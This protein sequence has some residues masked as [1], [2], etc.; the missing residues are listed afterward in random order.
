MIENLV[1]LNPILWIISFIVWIIFLLLFYKTKNS[2]INFVFIK[3]LQKIYKNSNYIFFIN[4]F[5]IFILI[6]IFSIIIA[7]PNIKNTHN[8]ITKDWIDIVLVFDLSLSMIAT[9]MKPS[10]LELWKQVLY[11]FVWEVENDRVWLVNFSWKPFLWSPLTFDYHFLQEVIKNTSIETINQNYSHLQWTAIW[12]ALLYAET[13]FDEDSIDR[14]KIIVLIT[15]WEVN[16]WI[17]PIEAVRFLREKNIKVHSVWIAWD[18]EVYI[19]FKWQRL[20]IWWVDEENL[21]AIASLTWWEYYRVRDTQSF[22]EIFNNLNILEKRE[23][24]VEQYVY[25]TPYYNIF[26]I[27]LFLFFSIFLLFNIYYFNRDYI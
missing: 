12:D 5:F 9:D 17:E 8:K 22:K 20:A 11:D 2:N 4:I 21:K 15:D 1:F 6:V 3:D 13:L 26:N 19:N 14:E 23:I 10:R 18:E 16:R 25:Y 7:N 24:D 27:V